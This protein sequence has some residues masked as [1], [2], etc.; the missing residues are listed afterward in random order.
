MGVSN[1]SCGEAF[2]S[3]KG[4]ENTPMTPDLAEL[5]LQVPETWSKAAYPSVMRLGAWM[6]DLARRTAFISKWVA[7]GTPMV[8]WLSAFFFPQVLSATC[9]KCLLEVNLLSSLWLL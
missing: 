3:A 4:W 6:A 1:A 8:F 7:D 5:G 2:Y 9:S